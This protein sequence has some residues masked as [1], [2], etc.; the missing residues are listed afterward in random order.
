MKLTGRNGVLRLLES[1]PILHGQ[2]PLDN[3]TVD[4]VKHDGAAWSNITSD[5]EVDD[6]NVETAFIADDND[7]IYIGSTSMFAMIQFLKGNGSNYAVASGALI[8]TYYDGTNFVTAL[9]GVS[10]GTLSGANC[11]GQDGYI[12]FKIPD[13]WAIGANSFNANLD[14]DKYYIKLMATTAPTTDPDADVLCPVDGQYF[15]VV[16]A[17]MD[18]TGPLGRPKTEEQL[19]LNRGTVDANAHYIQGPHGPI[20]EP[21]EISFSCLLDTTANKDKIL[22]ALECANPGAD[23]WTSTGVSTKGDTKNDGSNSNPAFVDSNKKTVNV[24]MLW[25]AGTDIP[26]GLAY[27]ETLFLLDQQSFS[28]A[29]EA[30]TLSCVG[31]TYGVIERIYGFGNHY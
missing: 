29:E 17:G 21:L 7:A 27:Y 28:E 24:Q 25:D 16:F 30:I 15:E 22:K 6:A 4:M 14:S 12:G 20:Y 26:F 31:A 18:F 3:L 5:V 1:S 11:F 10:D 2:A 23:R 9:S 13:D 8:A 19:V